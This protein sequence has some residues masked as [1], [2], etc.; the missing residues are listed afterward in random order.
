MLPGYFVESMK[1]RSNIP[2]PSLTRDTVKSSTKT[3]IGAYL[4]RIRSRYAYRRVVVGQTS[5]KSV[6]NSEFGIDTLG[7]EAKRLHPKL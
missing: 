6:G 1:P 2:T 3:V 4:V 5:A 7:A